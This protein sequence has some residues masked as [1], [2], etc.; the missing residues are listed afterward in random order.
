MEDWLKEVDNYNVLQAF[1]K[2]KAIIGR[3]SRIYASISGGADSDIVLDM[4]E[5]IR[6]D[7]PIKYVW[8]NTGLEF[9]ATKDHLGYLEKRYGIEIE[10]IRSKKPVPYCVHEYGIPFKS[11]F[12][13]ERIGSLQNRGFQWEDE[14]FEV[15]IEKYP[16]S[17]NALRWWCNTLIPAE[18]HKAT[19]FNIN[20]TPW[21]KEFLIENPPSFPISSKCCTYAKKQVSHE[22]KRDNQC[23]LEIVGVRKVEGG[24]RTAIKT[25][26]SENDDCDVFRPIYWVNDTDKHYYEQHF[27]I[28]HSDCYTRYGLRRTGCVG[29]P[30]ALDL[31]NNLHAIRQHEPR[32]Y[33]A[34]WNVFGEAYEYTRA[35]NS[36][37]REMNDKKKKPDQITMFE[38]GMI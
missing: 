11:K 2:A 10:Q 13:S 36:F 24:I 12:I 20:Y 15:L 33:K 4:C 25:C 26:F 37:R 21:L 22:Y 34:C 30:Y 23:D 16:N 1:L 3:H 29:C 14:P 17:A 5:R 9:Q 32:L 35:F 38:I 7:K 31:E 28:V 18:G 6:G 19:M 27:G 8:F